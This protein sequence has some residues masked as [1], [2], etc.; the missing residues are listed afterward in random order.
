MRKK[1]ILLS[2][3]ICAAQFVAQ[4]QLKQETRKFRFGSQNYAGLLEGENGTSF[5]LQTINGIR[6]KTWFAGIGTGL[7]YYYVR[8]IPLF[9]SV[10][11]FLESPKVP[12]YI[13]G[14]IGLSFPWEKD[15]QHYFDQSPGGSSSSLFWGAGLGY[16]FAVKNKDQGVLINFGYSYKH[17]VQESEYAYPCFT[18]PCPTEKERFDYHLKRLSI[19]VGWMF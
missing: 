5:Q 16:K 14:D 17:I 18:P 11:K 12:V 19:K 10:N 4:G 3:V 9:I 8:S 13:N 1:M 7:D 2:L 6:Y 15:Y